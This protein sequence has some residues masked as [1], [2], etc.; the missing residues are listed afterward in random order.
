MM[1]GPVPEAPPLCLCS[2]GRGRHAIGP[3]RVRAGRCI[4]ACGCGSFRLD[5]KAAVAVKSAAREKAG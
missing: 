5:P 1:P 2:H 3:K 4:R